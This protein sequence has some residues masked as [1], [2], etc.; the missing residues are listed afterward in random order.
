MAK[1]E[2]PAPGGEGRVEAVSQTAERD[3]DSEER[4]QLGARIAK[5]LHRRLRVYA[6]TEDRDVQDAVAE[7]LD[8]FLRRHGY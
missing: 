2:P 4:V 7:A 5:S 3:A 6:A 1:A 8:D